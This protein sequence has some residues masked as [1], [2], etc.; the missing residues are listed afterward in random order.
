VR[1]GRSALD[2]VPLFETIDDL[3]RAG[4]IMR[5]AFALPAWRALVARAATARK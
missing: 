3:E 2:I 1:D 5:E 4:R